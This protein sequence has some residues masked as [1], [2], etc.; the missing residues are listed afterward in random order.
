MECFLNH[1]IKIIIHLFSFLLLSQMP[2]Q[3]FPKFHATSRP[4]PTPRLCDN[5]SLLMPE[6]CTSLVQCMSVCSLRHAVCCFSPDVIVH[7]YGFVNVLDV[8]VG[9]IA[10]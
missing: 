8:Q 6:Q 5:Q 9:N 1:C 2:I 3:I 7:V 10:Y 4:P